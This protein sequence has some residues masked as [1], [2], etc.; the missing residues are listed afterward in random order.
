MVFQPQTEWKKR[1]LHDENRPPQQREMSM[2][3]YTKQF[4]KLQTWIG[5]REDE[6]QARPKMNCP[7]V[8]NPK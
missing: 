4:L 5:M 2:Q 1:V 6:E 8:S 3:E 7:K